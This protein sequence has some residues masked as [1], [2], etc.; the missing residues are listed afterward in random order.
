MAFDEHGMPGGFKPS[1]TY[2]LIHEGKSY[3]PPAIIA[4]A[5][6]N[7]NGLKVAPGFRVGKGTQCFQILE[8][9]G[10]EISVKASKNG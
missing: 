2:E 8:Q 7:S 3:P 1:H 9:C 4:L 5:A 6:E 10:F